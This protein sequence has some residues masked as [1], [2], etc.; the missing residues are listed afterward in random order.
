MINCIKDT[1]VY[2]SLN[3]TKTSSH[4]YLFYSADKVINNEIAKIFAKTFLCVSHSAE[5]NCAM[6]RQVESLSHPDFFLIDKNSVK[7]EDVNTLISKLDTRPISGDKKVFVILNFENV[8]EISQNKLLKSFEEPNASNIFIITTTNTDK[9]LK[10]IMSRITKIYVPKMTS[11][12]KKII[13]ND[14]N[15]KGID[16][17]HYLRLDSLTDMINFATNETFSSTLVAVKSTIKNL[18]TTADIPSVVSEINS[19]DNSLFLTILQE[20]FLDCIRNENSRKFDNELVELVSKK[21][22]HKAIVKCLP[23]I[24]DAYKKLLS[25]VNFIYIL[26]NLLFN[27]LK[28]KFLCK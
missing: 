27:I 5:D 6:C 4:A 2:K 25:N 28:E 10:T 22:N 16:I 23:L 18:N 9:V 13:S 11:E 12:D 8:N 15:S 14:L 19:V 21:F 1:S 24:E 20:L 3:L 7:V 17:S 26:D